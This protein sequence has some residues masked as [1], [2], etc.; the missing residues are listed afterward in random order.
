[1]SCLI[2]DAAIKKTKKGWVLLSIA[3]SGCYAFKYPMFWFSAAGV[4]KLLKDLVE[5]QSTLFCLH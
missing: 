4:E 2:V 5:K 3:F 1:M